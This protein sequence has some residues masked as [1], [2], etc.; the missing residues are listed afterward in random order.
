MKSLYRTLSICAVLI[1]FSSCSSNK[2]SNVGCGYWGYELKIQENEQEYASVD[3]R[4]V[5]EI[6][7]DLSRYDVVNID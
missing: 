7:V 5:Q 4:K 6:N 1:V 3:T 2:C